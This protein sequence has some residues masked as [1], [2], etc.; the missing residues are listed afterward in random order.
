MP[1]DDGIDLDAQRPAV[2]RAGSCLFGSSLLLGQRDVG[3]R[4]RAESGRLRFERDVWPIIAA[5]CVGCHGADGPKGGLDLRT[6]STMLRGGESGP[7]LDP[8]DPESSLLLE[9]ITRHEMPPGKARK[10]SDQEVSVVRAWIRAGARADHPDRM[11]QPVRDDPRRRS[12][13]L[14]VSAA[15]AAARAPGRRRRSRSHA[16][17]CLPARAGWSRRA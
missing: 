7:A 14:V 6:V 5:N 10:L 2:D 17:R 12:A 3:R 1:Y 4:C 13:V 16:D 8:S 9:R 15:L 11:P